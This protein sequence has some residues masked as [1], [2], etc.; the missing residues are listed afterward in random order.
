M[1]APRYWN[2]NR[3]K[4][5]VLNFFKDLFVCLRVS[6][7]GFI[8]LLALGGSLVDFTVAVAVGGANVQGVAEIPAKRH[9]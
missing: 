8:Y 2:T 1:I 3:I 6:P 4:S 7:E 5:V 9:F